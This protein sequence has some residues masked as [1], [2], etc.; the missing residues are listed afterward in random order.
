[1]HIQIQHVKSYHMVH[2]SSPLVA[3]ACNP[4][5]GF[6][7]GR[8][9]ATSREG[10]CDQTLAWRPSLVLGLRALGAAPE[11]KRLG[12]MNRMVE[13]DRILWTSLGPLVPTGKWSS[14]KP[15]GIGTLFGLEA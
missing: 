7:A 10:L 12:P 15:V 1:M 5:I 3:A 13:L 8:A 14:Q 11:L 4:I 6:C 2:A 9:E